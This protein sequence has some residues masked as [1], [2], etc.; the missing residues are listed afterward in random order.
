LGLPP[1]VFSDRNDGLQGFSVTCNY[2]RLPRRSHEFAGGEP[3]EPIE[4][5]KEGSSAAVPSVASGEGW[6]KNPNEINKC[7]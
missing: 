7:A 4:S 3:V 6:L 1:A 5:A 2:L